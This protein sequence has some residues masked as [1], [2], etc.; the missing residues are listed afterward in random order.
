VEKSRFFEA[1]VGGEE[2]LALSAVAAMERA[3]AAGA[4]AGA[5]AEQ[6]RGRPP[7]DTAS[8][9]GFLLRH[10]KFEGPPDPPE[11]GASGERKGQPG[12]EGP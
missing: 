8:K 12:G 6:A 9:Y 10:M 4:C 5:G 2:A 1:A 3:A 11:V 7:G